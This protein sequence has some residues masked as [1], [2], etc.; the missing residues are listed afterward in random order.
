MNNMERGLPQE[1]GDDVMGAINDQA[2]QWDKTM[3]MPI[4]GKHTP[5]EE[6]QPIVET[7]KS[8]N[9]K[10]AK[11]TIK[12]IVAKAL[13]TAL[14]ATGIAFTAPKVVEKIQD[15]DKKVMEQIDNTVQQTVHDKEILMDGQ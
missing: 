4:D 9:R 13:I 10:G 3:N 5:A 2:A 7:E 15:H 11:N 14:L 8:V 6:A 12:P 1:Y